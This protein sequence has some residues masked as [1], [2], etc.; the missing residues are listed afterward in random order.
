MYSW[1]SKWML[2]T[3]LD[4]LSASIGDYSGDLWD[5]QVGINY[6]AFKNI[7][8]GFYYNVFELDVDIDKSDWH[9]SAEFNQK[10]P[11]FTLTATW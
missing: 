8:F 2:Q 4:W 7:G 6:Q 1:S 10:G 11:M 3:R 9:G 5:A